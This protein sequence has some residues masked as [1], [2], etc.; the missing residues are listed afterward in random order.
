MDNYKQ[1]KIFITTVRAL[2]CA[3]FVVTCVFADDLKIVYGP[4][5]ASDTLLQIAS[6]LRPTQQTTTEQVMLAFLHVNP[7][8]FSDDSNVNSLMSGYLLKLPDAL[9]IQKISTIG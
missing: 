4:T 5:I 7:Q 1:K 3:F 2:I 8:A 6:S 9:Q